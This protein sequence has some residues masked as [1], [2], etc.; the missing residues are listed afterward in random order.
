MTPVAAI[1]PEENRQVRFAAFGE[2][3][4]L[5]VAATPVPEPGRGQVLIRVEASSVQYTDTLIRRGIYPG[6]KDKPPLTPGY[7]LVGTIVAVGPEVDGWKEGDRVCDLTTIGGNT[8]FALRPADG[9]V[10]VPGEVDATEAATLV[11]SWLTAYQCLHRAAA[12]AKGQRVLV[13]GGNGAVGQAT[14][15]LAQLAGAEVW[16][17]G[18][19]RHHPLLT[20]L[21]ANPLPREGWQDRAG[22]GFDIVTDGICFDGF[23]STYAATKRG[24]TLV[25][26]GAS[27][28]ANRGDSGIAMRGYAG[29]FLK[30]LWPD[31]KRVSIY[32]ITAM[33][34]QEPAWFQEDLSRLMV[35]L[36]RG[37]IHPNVA[38]RLSF[39][40]V[41]DAHRRLE[42]GGLRGKLVLDPWA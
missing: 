25:A 27:E 23:R 39:E 38:E 13:I 16:A 1:A 41:A 28:A 37:G 5:E 42:E 35:L 12:V 34:K 32:S 9:L 20:G 33:R 31:G 8:R 4:E 24:G 22:G 21:G 19:A 26:I 30:K 11:L 17:T 15:V 2:P 6:L 10:L 36:Q 3:D 14:I 29:L 40:Q 7:D 18:S